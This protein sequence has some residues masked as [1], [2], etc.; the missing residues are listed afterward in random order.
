MMEPT[1][2]A[3]QMIDFQKTAFNN[4]F[5]AMIVLQ[6]QTE[7]M[8]AAVWAQTPGLSEEGKKG[9][10]TWV[11]AY[12]KGRDDFKKA[13]DDYFAKVEEFFNLSK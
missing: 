8:V 6:E 11:K 13:T 4:A 9:I 5:N 3:K 12:K 10:D 1:K 7:K 2:I